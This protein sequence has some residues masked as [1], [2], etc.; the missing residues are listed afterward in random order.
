LSTWY[1]HLRRERDNER[2]R[3]YRYSPGDDSSRAARYAL[4]DGLAGVTN[5]VW[6][7]GLL[8]PWSGGGFFAP[9]GHT[10]GDRGVW[11]THTRTK[12]GGS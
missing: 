6:S 7:N 1:T 12:G 5:V 11:Y 10:N 3:G 2:A 8:D 4:G 9:P